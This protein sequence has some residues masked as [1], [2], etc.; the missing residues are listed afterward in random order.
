MP[1]PQLKL[2]SIRDFVPKLVQSFKEGY[3]P[4]LLVKDLFSGVTVGIV[5]LPLAMAFAIGAGA[6]PA[7]GL[8]TA[9]VAGF[10]MAV[11]SG[12]K[13]QVSGPT[14]AFVVLIADVIV[15]HGMSGLILATL[16]AGVL[17]VLLGVSGLGK[18]IKFIPYPVTTG[19]TTGIGVIIAA[20]QFKDFLGLSVPKPSAEFVGRIEELFQ[21]GG[22]M[23][24]TALGV[25]AVTLLAI[26]FIR[27]LAPR[28]PAAVVA[29]AA[30][31]AAVFFLGIDV[32]TVGSRFGAIPSG[33]P[34]PV[35]PP[36]SL[37][38]VRE[39]FPSAIT[40]AMLAAIESLLSAVVAD[41]MTGDKH[42]ANMELVAQGLGNIGSALFGGIPATGAIARTA[43]NIKNGAK[44]PISGIV[45]AVVL[46]LFTL[47][48]AP[49]A[50]A[51]P[52]AALASV[53]LVVAWD[54]S[55][56]KRF[57]GMRYAPKSDYVVMLTT[58]ALTVLV[59]LTVAVEV[60][61]LLAVFLFLRRMTEV[62]SIGPSSDFVTLQSVSEDDPNPVVTGRVPK[63]CEIYEI[64]GPFFFGVADLLQDTLDQLERPPEVFVL[65]MRK[66]PAIDATGI[67]ALASFHKHCAKH[68][69]TLVLACVREQP[70][71]AIDGVNLTDTIGL[72]NIVP[73]VDMA[74]ERA[75]SVIEANAEKARNHDRAG[76]K[77]VK[78]KV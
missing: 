29:V 72:D 8:Y 18:L 7:Q 53:L 60:G 33:F 17:L 4:S 22:T 71:K 68:G 23:R 47:A 10:L 73:N 31:T 44:S 56:L 69:T 54:M 61:L 5:A 41:G 2:V 66:V 21:F 26:I 51:I 20:G 75:R 11:F 32:E 50:E 48:L 70:K 9:V 46:L 42:N 64:D 58:F 36:L 6:S 16:I 39:V 37:K 55:E 62:T 67:N 38:L 65:R 1:Q 15:R 49:L 13:Y 30:V 34:K 25:G 27:K 78:F 63:G 19:F 43:T 35:L 76:D 40:L 74:L 45:H 12:S 14:G 52:L 77:P 59:D 24:F 28:I 57:I 3:S